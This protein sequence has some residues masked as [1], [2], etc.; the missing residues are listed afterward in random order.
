MLIGKEAVAGPKGFKK[1]TK[2]TREVLATSARASGGSSPRRRQGD[3]ENRSLRKQYDDA[4]K[5][6]EQRFDRQG[7]EAAARRRT[8]AGRDEDGQGLRRGEAQAAA[9]RQDGRPSRQQGRRLAIVPIEDMPFLEDGTPVDIV[10]NPLGVPSRMN[11]G[12]I[13]ETHLGWACAG[14]GKQIGER[15]KPTARRPARHRS[16]SRHAED[17]LRR[18]GPQ[19]TAEPTTTSWSNSP[20]NL[21]RACRSRRRCSTARKEADIVRC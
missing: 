16:R 6:L 15:S 10:L 12:Q 18:Q 3:G 13:L 9:G 5:R 2:I 8:A 11:V 19:R 4:K 1:G 17:D 7:R 14:I 20:R 21:R